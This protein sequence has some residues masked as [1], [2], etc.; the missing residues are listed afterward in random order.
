MTIQKQKTSTSRLLEIKEFTRLPGTDRPVTKLQNT[1]R[2]SIA[3]Q[4]NTSDFQTQQRK[5]LAQVNRFINFMGGNRAMY[6]Y[7]KQYQ[8]EYK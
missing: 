5:N 8:K 3:L 6:Q 1:P 7:I 2:V 4:K